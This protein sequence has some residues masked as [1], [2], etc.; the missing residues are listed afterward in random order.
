MKKKLYL[1]VMAFVMSMMCLSGCAKKE[2]SSKLVIAYQ[3]GLA[4]APMEIMKANEL[5]E[6]HYDGNVE[7][8]W[9]VM[10]SGSAITE[11]I[12]AG[13]IDVAAMGTGPFITGVSKGVPMKMY[14]PV[15]NM[16]Y[17]L[18]TND[19]SIRSLQDITSEDKIAIVNVGSVQHVVLAMA[20]EQILGDAHALDE[21]LVAMSHPDGMASLISG[22][23]KLHLT[24]PP[25]LFQEQASGDFSEVPVFEGIWDSDNTF[26]I[27]VVSNK[28]AEKKPELVKAI[29]E[30]TKEAMGFLTNNKEES[31]KILSQ[32]QDVAEEDMLTW[33]SNESLSYSAEAKGVMDMAEFMQKAGFIET[34]PESI[35]SISVGE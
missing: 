10:N 15:A 35:E 14:S 30:A 27:G 16:P 6:K 3:Y 33:L 11:G 23:V 17:G 2:E 13:S 4:F 22:S 21:N 9:R 25:Y 8:E 1:I 32:S 31:A 5:I 18:M 20:C 26:E 34:M 19:N 7:I 29:Q 28:L 12:T 24:N